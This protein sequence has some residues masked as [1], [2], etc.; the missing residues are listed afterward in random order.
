MLSGAETMIAVVGRVVF[1]IGAALACMFGLIALYTAYEVVVRI[2]TVYAYR[3]SRALAVI[4]IPLA[5]AI[6]CWLGGKA[7]RDGFADE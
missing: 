3:P 1:W 7:A 4:G 6:V 2:G 5:T